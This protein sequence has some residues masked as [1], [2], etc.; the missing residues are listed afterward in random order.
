M[1]G[2]ARARDG[3]SLLPP[4]VGGSATEER[5][6]VACHCERVRASDTTR[7]LARSHHDRLGGR[8]LLIGL[9]VLLAAACAGTRGP[10]KP[11]E[12]VF[13]PAAPEI[14]RIQFLA[15]VGTDLDVKGPIS[16]LEDFLYGERAPTPLMKPYGL[17]IHE[18]KIFVVDTIAAGVAIL[19]IANK[20]TETLGNK[21]PGRLRKPINITV[22]EDGTRYVTDRI[23]GRV[24][25]YDDQNRY[26]NAFGDPKSWAPTDVEIADDELY[27][28]DRESGQVLVL[29][30]S[31]GEVLRRL[32]S[33][34]VG[35]AQFMFPTNLAIDGDGNVYVSDTLNYRIQKID[36]MGN[37]LQQFGEA[38]DGL[39]QFAR[40]KGIAVDR[41]N[42]LYAVDAAFMNVQ[43]FDAEGRLLL[44]FGGGG[45]ANPGDMYLPAKIKIDYDNLELFAD[46]V[47]PGH[48]VE[49]LILV[50]NQYGP[51]K[52]NIYGLL[53]QSA[54]E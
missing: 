21:A 9:A 16:W 13:Y 36:P 14:P 5:R 15:T 39:G 12:Y 41:E 25:I 23:L 6:S 3:E 22:D 48:E 38:G 20:K 45:G 24:L 2:P 29:D 30:K 53:K 43:V 40:P 31:S 10:E 8:R 33:E 32:G 54:G 42:R 47:A 37:A 28:A 17:D 27:V 11:V 19:D 1:L 34:G 26:L 46:R 50:T 18:G 51:N 49:Y 44:V 4:A 7:A 52:V 35:V